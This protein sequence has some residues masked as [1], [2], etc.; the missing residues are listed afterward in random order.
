LDV[1]VAESVATKGCLEK[2][3]SMRHDLMGMGFER[4]GA[5]GS[6]RMTA[7]ENRT[8]PAEVTRA[9]NDIESW[10]S[11]S[12]TPKRRIIVRVSVLSAYVIPIY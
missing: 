12:E 2:I 8:R 1:V 4:K 5:F 3:M 6:V 11:L 7:R 10:P 9:L